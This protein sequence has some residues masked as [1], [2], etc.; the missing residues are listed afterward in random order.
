M[1]WPGL[2]SENL[3]FQ[4]LR[5]RSAL[6]VFQVAA[7]GG[8]RAAG[9]LLG[10]IVELGAFLQLSVNRVGFRLGLGND[11][12]TVGFGRCSLSG[13]SRLAVWRSGFRS[14]GPAPAV[15]S[16]FVLV[17]KLPEFPAGVT[18]M[19]PPTSC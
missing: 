5:Q 3:I 12:I 17:V 4:L 15:A 9:I 7:L 14:G 18:L 8:S 19:W 2:Q 11:L 6:E 16:R 13:L 10:E 1:N